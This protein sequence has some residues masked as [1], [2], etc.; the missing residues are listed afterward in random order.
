MDGHTDGQT[1]ETG[2][3]TSTLSNSRPKKHSSALFYQ[4]IAKI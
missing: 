3:I 2:F 4:I 1:F